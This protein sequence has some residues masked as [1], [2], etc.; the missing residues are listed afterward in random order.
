MIT[1]FRRIRQQLIDSGNITKYLLYAVGEILLV[2]IGILIALQVNNWNEGRLDANK[3]ESYRSALI[4]DLQADNESYQTDIDSLEYFTILRRQAQQYFRENSA[5]RQ[6]LRRTLENMEQRVI[7]VD[8]TNSNT[9]QALIS[10]GDID[11]FSENKSSAIR[12]LR[13]LQAKHIINEAEDFRLLQDMYAE[14]MMTLP[15]LKSNQLITQGPTLEEL[16]STIPELEIAR[17]VNGL[18]TVRYT[19]E[20]STLRRLTELKTESERLLELLNDDN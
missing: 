3:V 8:E 14:L 20:Q 9:I 7:N 19:L 15:Y 17:L 6:S 18:F 13:Q 5:S 12:Q 10:S 2:V 4:A 16:W 11:L 1:L